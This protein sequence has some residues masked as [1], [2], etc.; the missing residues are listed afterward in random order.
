MPEPPSLGQEILAWLHVGGSCAQNALLRLAQL[1]VHPARGS[2]IPPHGSHTQ[3]ESGD[4]KQSKSMKAT[5]LKPLLWVGHPS[6]TATGNALFPSLRQLIFTSPQA[7]AVLT[8]LIIS[9]C[10]VTQQLIN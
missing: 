2:Q 10:M 4:I 7:S 6:A 1:L 3:E 9:W 8:E 5:N